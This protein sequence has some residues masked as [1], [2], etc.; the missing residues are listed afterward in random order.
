MNHEQLM[1][2]GRGK[3]KAGLRVLK[4]NKNKGSAIPERVKESRVLAE[5]V[6]STEMYSIRPPANFQG[7]KVY[8][9]LS[10]WF[11]SFWLIL[12]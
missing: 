6:T 2:L 10:K 5:Q 1:V 11:L 7:K 4:G 8:I 12:C 9:G 3:D